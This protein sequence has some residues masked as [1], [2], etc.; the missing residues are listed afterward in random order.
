MISSAPPYFFIVNPRAGLGGRPFGGIANQL[1]VRG[2]PFHA[3]ATTGPGDA[4]VLAQ[5]ARAGE[6]K[7]I[8]CV[9]GDGTVNDVLNGLATPEGTIDD[10][11]PLG[12]IPTGT[13]Q[14]FARSIGIALNRGEATRQLLSGEETRLDVGRITFGDGRRHFFVNM[15]GA[16]FDAEVA[17]RAQD[18]RAAMA[19][20]P[21]HMVG[22]ASAFAGYQ[23]QEIA[24]S[25][26]DDSVPPSRSR[27]T[28]V[29]VANGPSYAGV[30]RIAPNAVPDDGLLDLVVIG[31]VDKI[32][33]LMNLG[34]VF[35]GTHLEH[36]KV[37]VYR[38]RSLTLESTGEA[39]VQ[40]DGEVV[41]RLPAHVD[42]LPGALRVIR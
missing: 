33:M 35:T 23:N 38:T 14:D 21:A 22:L 12:V 17:E 24:I 9:G 26:E 28:M 25:V 8:V 2:I 5:L 19:S 15:V 41:G 29:V 11:T 34:R 39:L 10:R 42:V 16:G 37:D 6:F 40:A 3:A 36:A 32:E 7:A 1:R 30:L 4:R 13:A 20:I 27:C 31:D 18:A